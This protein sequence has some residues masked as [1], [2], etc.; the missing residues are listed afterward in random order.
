MRFDITIEMGAIS[1]GKYTLPKTLA[2]AVNVLA[3]LLR[4]SEK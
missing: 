4:Q 3:V 2:F 1:L